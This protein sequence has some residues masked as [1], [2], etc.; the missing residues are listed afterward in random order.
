MWP[1]V[2]ALH[3]SMPGFQKTNLSEMGFGELLSVRPFWIDTALLQALKDHWDDDCNCFLLP[4]GHMTP[5][6]EDVTRIT[7][8]RVHG[9]PVTGMLKE[10]Y[11]E[12]ARDLLGYEDDK[13]GPLTSILGSKLTGLLWA[14]EL[15]KR[16]DE[17]L[18]QYVA[19]VRAS[20]GEKWAQREGR[21][22]RRELRAFLLLLLS[23]LLFVTKN[24][25]ISLRYLTVIGRLQRVGQYA[26]GAAVLADLYYNLSAPSGETGIG[27][28]S[29]LL[30]VCMFKLHQ[31]WIPKCSE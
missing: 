28:F 26:W 10:D 4:W 25:R 23:R 31:P 27:G 12:A 16:P 15:R 8:L 6:L 7:G 17:S 22:A 21:R 18:D 2:Y 13:T 3:E 11:R 9:R 29:P 5:S 14:S 30:Q 19:R 1:L 20:V 24:S